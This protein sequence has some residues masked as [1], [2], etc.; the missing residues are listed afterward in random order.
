[1]SW[2]STVVVLLCF[3]STDTRGC[4]TYQFHPGMQNQTKEQHQTWTKR[5]IQCQ[6]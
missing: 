6:R 4:G 2:H 3:C 1:M 5:K